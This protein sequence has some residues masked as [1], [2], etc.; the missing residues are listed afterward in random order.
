MLCVRA[1][2]LD[3][4]DVISLAFPAAAG[5]EPPPVFLRADRSLDYGRVM[6]VMGELNRAGLN[7]VSLVTTSSETAP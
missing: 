5:G 3:A 7:R 2:H 1:H 6:R 4:A